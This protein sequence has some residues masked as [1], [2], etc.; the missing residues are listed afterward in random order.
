MA[1]Q[2]RIESPENY[3]SHMGN[4]AKSY[5]YRLASLRT[6]EANVEK[7]LSAGFF[8]LRRRSYDI[9]KMYSSNEL[10]NMRSVEYGKCKDLYFPNNCIEDCR[11]CTYYIFFPA[12][13][14]FQEGITW[15]EDYSN[16][17]AQKMD[18]Q[19]N[20]MKAIF[21]KITKI[22]SEEVQQELKHASR[23]LQH[24]MDQKINIDIQLLEN[25]INSEDGDNL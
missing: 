22:N 3:Y 2:S 4:I 10:V 19:V 9:G 15:L 1:G 20:M 5:T 24:F 17:I 23:N 16:L 13:N 7:Q 21:G 11:Q 25:F 6:K 12:I 8:G 14:Q 18:Q